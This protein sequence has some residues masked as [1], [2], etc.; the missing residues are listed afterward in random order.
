MGALAMDLIDRANDAAD[1]LLQ[2]AIERRQ[3]A[4][5]KAPSIIACGHCHNCTAPVAQGLQFCDSF[6]RDDWQR[7]QNARR[8]NGE[9]P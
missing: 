2:D 1:M 4:A 7:V 9:Q 8:R 6:C 5:Q 3:L